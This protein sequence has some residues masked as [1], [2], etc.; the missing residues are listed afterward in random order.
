MT[1]TQTT[2]TKPDGL[3]GIEGTQF[4]INGTNIPSGIQISFKTEHAGK[5]ANLYRVV[6]GKLVFVSCGK[7]VANGKAVMSNVSEKGDYIAMICEFSD[8]QGDVNN[9]GIVNPK[10]STSS[11]SHFLEIEKCKNQLVADMNRDN[12]INPKDSYLILQ[13][14]LGIA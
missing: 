8:L 9:D 11:L 10:D 13:R 14:Y 1:I 6:D 2:T 5:F 7:I 4:S 12:F 3:R